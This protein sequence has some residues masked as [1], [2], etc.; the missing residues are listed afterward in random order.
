MRSH[1]L[2]T[3]VG[4]GVLLSC[5]AGCP[6]EQTINH[7]TEH[8]TLSELPVGG[9]FTGYTD[10]QFSQGV[11]AGKQVHLLSATL[12]SS[13]N[14]FSWATS[15]VGSSADNESGTI[16]IEKTSFSGAKSPADL[17]VVDT[18]D[19]LKLFPNTQ[20]FRVYWAIQFSDH[21]A[22]SYPNGITLTFDYEVEIK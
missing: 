2:G 10:T 17:D 11:P 21:P 18:G 3:A 4:L 14:E 22:M 13:S 1:F 20:N 7:L 9:T 12:S 6:G 15:L 5:L 16:I 19:L 8:L